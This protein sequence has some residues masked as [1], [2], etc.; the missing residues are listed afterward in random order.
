MSETEDLFEAIIDQKK[1]SSIKQE[2]KSNLKGKKQEKPETEDLIKKLMDRI[3]L[4]EKKL[5]GKD[6]PEPG[7]PANEWAK[8]MAQEKANRQPKASK[9]VYTKKDGKVLKVDIKV[10]G[11]YSSYIGNYKKHKDQLIP[12]ISQWKKEGS[13]VDEFEL[14]EKTKEIMANLEG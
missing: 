12:L 10:N 14:E 7:N 5:E 2:D 3:N 1:D 8:K 4:L 6:S 13:W 9:T 11:A